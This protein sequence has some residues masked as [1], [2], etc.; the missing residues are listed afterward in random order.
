MPRRRRDEAVARRLGQRLADRD[1]RRRQ[2]AQRG[3]QTRRQRREQQQGEA[4]AQP[5]A[6]RPTQAHVARHSRPRAHTDMVT[7]ALR[8][9]LAAKMRELAETTGMSLAK[10]LSDMVLVYEREV[11]A[12]YE[13]GTCL[14]RWKEE[15]AG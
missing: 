14:A 3:A 1:E 11:N 5:A 2:A 13:P 7:V 6:E 4:Q 10:L 9:P 8:G 12:G 15:R